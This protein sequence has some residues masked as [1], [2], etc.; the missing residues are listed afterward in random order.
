MLTVDDL[1]EYVGVDSEYA[2]E[3]QTRRLERCLRAA[4][5]W[6]VGAVGHEEALDDERGEEL[7]QMAAAEMFE[8]RSLTDDRLSR[9]AGS[10][11]L[12]SLNRMA[13]DMLMQLRIECG[14]RAAEEGGAT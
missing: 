10:K 12:A 5:G 11:A 8:N 14:A 9:Y 3:A 6:L 4:A 2:D 1:A 13:G 7:V